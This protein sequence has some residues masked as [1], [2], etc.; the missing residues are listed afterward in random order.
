MT[1]AFGRER[2]LLQ[3]VKDPEV[4]NTDSSLDNIIRV[5]IVH[6]I[7]FKAWKYYRMLTDRL[8]RMF[9]KERMNNILLQC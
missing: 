9:V 3:S 5:R 1:Q 8:E 4:F 2:L 7:Q 6:L